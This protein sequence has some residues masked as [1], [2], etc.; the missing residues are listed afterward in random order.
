MLGV[1]LDLKREQLDAIERDHPRDNNRCKI[2]MLGCWLDTTTNPTWE[3]VAE[4]LDLMGKRKVA[5][6]IRK[7]YSTKGILHLCSIV[8]LE[9]QHI[10]TTSLLLGLRR[11]R[12]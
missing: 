7:K 3:A 10:H 9:M 11:I 4:A 8:S 5:D 6:T 2:D 1:Y 12:G